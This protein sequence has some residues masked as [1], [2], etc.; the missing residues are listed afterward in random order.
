MVLG[1]KEDN[2]E[3]DDW[4]EEDRGDIFYASIDTQS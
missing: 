3:A 2:F 1:E 4:D